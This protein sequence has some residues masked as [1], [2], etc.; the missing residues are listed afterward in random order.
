MGGEEDFRRASHDSHRS[1]SSFTLDAPDRVRKSIDRVRSIAKSRGHSPR[2]ANSHASFVPSQKSGIHGSESPI[3]QISPT[4]DARRV[5]EKVTIKEIPGIGEGLQAAYLLVSPLQGWVSSLATM[6]SS[7]SGKEKDTM[8]KNEMKLTVD[9]TL[10]LFGD[11]DVFV[12]AKT[13]HA[14]AENLT[15]AGKGGVGSQF[16]YKE[17]SGAGHFWHDYEAVQVLEEEVK[18]FISNL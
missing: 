2:R 16:R 10:A 9:P 18:G 15:E 11:N 13:L 3:E 8:N 12:S 17:I 7:K 14:W 1:R 4:H 6:W 5:E